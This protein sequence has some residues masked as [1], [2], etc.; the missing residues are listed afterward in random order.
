LDKKMLLSWQPNNYMSLILRFWSK[1]AIGFATL[2]APWV[3]QGQTA[4]T[5]ESFE[6]PVTAPMAGD[7]VHPQIALRPGG[8]LMVWQ[9]NAT[10][11]DGMGISAQVLD[12]NLYPSMSA[13]RINV[14]G[15]G[16]QENPQV[17]LLKNGGAVVVWQGGEVGSQHIF[18]RFLTSSNTFSTSDIAVSSYTD[19]PQVDPQVSVMADGSVLVSYSSIGQDGSMSGIFAQRLSAAGVKVGAEFQIN[20]FTNYNQRTSA[21]AVLGNGTYVVA[22]ISEQQRS[23]Y[24][25]ASDGSDLKWTMEG[26]QVGSSIDVYARLFDSNNVAL[27]NEFLVNTTNK[28]CANPTLAATGNGGF[29]VAWSQDNGRSIVNGAVQTNGWDV[30]ARVYD[31]QGKAVTQDLSVNTYKYGEQFAPRIQARGNDCLVVWTSLGQ[32]GSREGVY[33]RGLSAS[34][35]FTT[36][37]FL[38]NTT[39]VSQ[40]MHP[41]V[42]TDGGSRF[43]VVWT[44]FIGGQSSFDL[45]GQRYYAGDGVQ[46]LTQPSAPMVSALSQGRLSVAWPAVGGA[47]VSRYVVFMDDSS[48]GATVTNNFYQATGLAASTSHSF[49]VQ[50]VL[51]DGQVSPLSDA[52]VGVTWGED[53]NGDGLPDDW[54]AK[55]WGPKS[56]SWPGAS[57]DSDGDGMTNYEEFL[58]GTDPRDPSSVLKSKLTA[59]PLG[60]RLSWNT[61]QG[62]IY[63]VQSSA[64]L[65][66]WSNAGSPRY[67]A[68][69]NDSTLVNMNNGTAYFRIVRVR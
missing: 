57:V 65:L 38:V 24:S 27:G 52:G 68:G 26:Q 51:A 10:D 5:P 63:Q 12:A 61:Q 41:A 55:Y 13:F 47:V 36:G 32:D 49:R 9:D 7:Q 33:G 37:E 42:A 15:A 44:S 11:G 59:D 46:P 69:T 16:D 34:G 3:L 43:L 6:Y 40:Q 2:A 31:G 48:T 58:A 1:F 35:V 50:Y 56:S 64:D 8:G 62:F 23:S 14:E 39:T 25:V 53:L 28:V 67:A 45:F 4:V 30:V 60:W 18:A 29:V 54:Q 21:S 17:A 66:E 20:Q 22:W 19:G